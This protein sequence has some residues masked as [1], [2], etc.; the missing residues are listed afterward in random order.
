M[1]ASSQGMVSIEQAHEDYRA[2]RKQRAETTCRQ[3][4]ARDPNNDR[5][6]HLLGIMALEVRQ[7]A[8]AAQLFMRALD[9]APHKAAYYVNLATALHRLG[10]PSEAAEVLG[11]AISTDPNLAEAHFNL[12]RALFDLGD[13]EGSFSALERA[14]QLS[15]DRSEIH[16]EF[17]R[18]LNTR[19]E[20]E[21]SVESYRKAMELGN[22][23]ADIHVELASVLRTQRHYEEALNVARIAVDLA[24]RLLG[25]H[26]ELGKSLLSSQREGEAIQALRRAVQLDP[27]SAE[28][29]A[30]LGFALETVGHVQ[31]AIQSMQCSLTLAPSDHT[32][33]SNIIYLRSFVPGTS[34]QTLLDEAKSW[35][36]A[37]GK[38]S[39]IALPACENDLDSGRR[40]RVGY[41][42]SCFY[43]HC[44]SFFTVP[45]LEHH[46]RQAVEVYCYSAAGH[47]DSITQRIRSVADVWRDVSQQDDAQL[48]R[49]V[50]DDRVD[51]L[52]DL[53]MHMGNSRLMAFA[54]RP[55]P[56]QICWLAYPGTT[57]L[58]A[59]DYRITDRYL[60]PPESSD[61][62][63]SE[64]SI[65]LPDCFWC[66]DP[67]T[68][69]VEPGPLPATQQGYV[70]FG[71]LNHVRKVNE[72]TL[73]LWADILNQVHDSRLL[74]HAPSSASRSGIVEI[75]A[76]FGVQA[77]RVTFAD[78]LPRLEYLNLYRQVDIGLDTF[79]YQGHTT[80]LDSLW[81]GVPVVSL[82][83]PLLVG[84]AAITL[85]A[86]LE[87]GELVHETNE[88]FVN[89]AVQLASDVQRMQALRASLRS[90][91]EACPLM[92][93]HRFARNME[94]AYRSA[95]RLRCEGNTG[96]R[97]PL[98]ISPWT[99]DEPV[100]RRT[101]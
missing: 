14:A 43:G 27:S 68:S 67:L 84:R 32:M 13:K 3:L 36:Q 15:S 49:A 89:A 23:A 46:D 85:A 9:N 99:A 83:G 81:M 30:N 5:A 45:L 1:A 63:Y 54:E 87:L 66:Y 92:D 79:P 77:Q 18:R 25:A 64:R 28:A 51:I 73:Q 6:L 50:R 12:A 16:L 24:P 42:S 2:G 17:A 80:S 55:A 100:L 4:L 26:I 78:R 74:L 41:V 40:L 52:V 95:W 31:E 19:G 38:P 72:A 75:L 59:M 97:S 98:L 62:P 10:K 91:M 69:E 53:T 70:T 8:M 93:A 34:A 48:A 71:C 76:R 21:R 94:A 65:V 47:P 29:H 60:D 35:D 58:A 61:W 101:R 20:F 11:L 96:D 88:G 22:G 37:F 57:G 86:N 90:R 33:L 44:Q 7:D 82:L 56:V 39:S